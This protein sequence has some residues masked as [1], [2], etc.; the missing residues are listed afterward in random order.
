MCDGQGGYG[1]GQGMSAQGP[2]GGFSSQNGSPFNSMTAGTAGTSPLA[3]ANPSWGG[4]QGAS[5]QQGVPQQTPFRG[6]TRKETAAVHDPFAALTGCQSAP[7]C[8]VQAVR[9]STSLLL[10]PPLPTSLLCLL[11]RLSVAVMTTNP[12][13][14]FLLLPEQVGVG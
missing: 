1:Q 6:P 2:Q 14:V 12:V 4:A 9:A 11:S 7:W 8:G 10:S 3:Q 13:M 5:Q